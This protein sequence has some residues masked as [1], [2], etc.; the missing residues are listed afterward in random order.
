MKKEAGNHQTQLEELIEKLTESENIDSE[1][2]EEVAEET[3]E[4]L[5][6]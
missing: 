4:K 6:K 1:S 3:Q 5:L 2:I